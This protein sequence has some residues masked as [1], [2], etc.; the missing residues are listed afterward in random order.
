MSLDRLSKTL[1]ARL[2]PTRC[3]ICDRGID[4]FMKAIEFTVSSPTDK[5]FG[6]TLSVTGVSV[7]FSPSY[8]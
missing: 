3:G 6:K 2:E 1:S 5:E 4:T 7:T 8:S